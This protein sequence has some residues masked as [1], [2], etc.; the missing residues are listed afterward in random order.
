MC[1][2]GEPRVRL[3]KPQPFCSTHA[4]TSFASELPSCLQMKH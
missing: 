4:T 1:L 3:C 2:Y